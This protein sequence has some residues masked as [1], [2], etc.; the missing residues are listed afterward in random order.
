MAG[1]GFCSG[2][3]LAP[4]PAGAAPC[5]RLAAGAGAGAAGDRPRGASGVVE[6]ISLLDFCEDRDAVRLNLPLMEPM[7]ELREE[8]MALF[9]R[10]G[11]SWVV[12]V[13]VEVKYVVVA[14]CGGGKGTE[15]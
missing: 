4:G 8:D 11:E 13:V 10:D 9:E 6:G 5:C 15:S 12:V 14:I 2:L 1:E 3:R 7:K